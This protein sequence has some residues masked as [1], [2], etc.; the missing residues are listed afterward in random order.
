MYEGT[1]MK[2]NFYFSYLA[3]LLLLIIFLPANLQA[4]L[5]G[6]YTIPGTPFATIKAAADSLNLAGVGAGGVTFNVTAGY[7][8]SITAD[9]TLTATGSSGSAIIFQKSGGGANPLITRTDAGALATSTLG[10]AGDAIIRI[11][12]TDYITFN[13]IDVTASDQGIEYGYLTHKPDGTNGC[14]FVTITNCVV[15][16]TKGTSAYVA[17]IYIGNGT[18]STS[19]A[20]GVTVTAP[21]GMN[22]DINVTGNTIQNVHAGIIL[23]G[24]TAMP[25]SFITI[26][27]SSAGN[28]IQNYGGGSATTTYGVYFIYVKSPS[29]AYNTIDNAGGGGTPHTSILYAVFYSSGVSGDL[30]C[31]NNSFTLANAAASSA[32]YFMYSTNTC[33]SETIENN[34]FTTAGTMPAGSLYFIYLSNGTPNKTISGNTT[35]GTI[36]KAGGLTYCYYNLGSPTSGTETITNNTFSNINVASGTS[37]FYGFYTNT[38]SGQDRVMSNNT[39]SNITHSGTGTIYCIEAI[40][41]NNNQVFDNTIH[42][43]TGGG[44]IYCLYGGGVN[45]MFYNNN[46]YS[47]TSTTTSTSALYGIYSSTSTDITYYN[48]FLSDLKAPDGTCIT[49]STYGIYVTT[50]TNANLFYNTVYLDY[51]SNVATNNSAGVY[52]SSTPSSI[53]MRNNIIVNNVDNSVGN[54]VMA[55]RRSNTTITNLSANTNNNL[56]YA[57]TPSASHLIFYDGT[58]A[59][60]TLA[61]YKT[62]VSPSELASITENPPFINI[63]TPPYDL[64]MSTSIATQTESGGTPVAGITVDYDGDTRSAT[65]PDVGAD[66]FNGI[67][68]DVT[69]PSITYTPFGPTSSTSARTLTASILDGSGV[70]T[71][72]I[73]L[74]V[75]YWQ[76]NSGSWNATTSTYLSGSDYEFT[77]GSGVTLNDTVKYYICA[78]DNATPSNVGAFPSVGA[79]GFTANPPAAA[80]PPTD[81]SSYLIVGLPLSGDYTVGILDFNMITGKNISFEKVIKK[82]IKEVD[83]LVPLSDIQDQK[84]KDNEIVSTKSP[85]QTPTKQLIEVE[86]TTWIPME[87]GKPYVGD[88]Y[89]KKFDYPEINFPEGI[90]GI[91]LTITAAVADLNLRGVSSPVR[92]LLT[93]A[94]YSTGETFPIFIDI[95]N[96]SQPTATNTVTFK[97]NTGVTSTITSSTA[98]YV[99]G[100]NGCDYIIFDGSNAVGGTTRDLSI[101]ND[102]TVTANLGIV[103]FHNGLKG[104]TNITVTNCIVKGSPTPTTSYG[105]FLNAAGGAFHNTSFINNVIKNFRIGIQFSGVSGS[106]TNDGLI[107]GN[108]VG[109]VTEPLTVSGILGSQVDNLTI[110]GNEIFG[111]IEGNTTTSKYGISLIAGSTNSKIQKNNIHDFYYTGTSGYGCFGIRYN[112]DATTVT[113]ISNNLIYDIKGDGDASSLTYTPAGIY[114][115]TGGNVGLYYNSIYMSGNTLGAGTTYNGRSACV[116]IASGITL[117]DIRD[118]IFQNSM[119]SFPGS[120]RINTT[121]GVYCSSANTAFT[122]INYNDYFVNGVGP[123]VGYL[124]GDQ[125]NLA[126]WQTATGQDLNS[127]SADPEFT[128]LTDLRPASTSPVLAAGTPIAGITTDYLGVTRSATNPSMGA[129]EMGVVTPMSGVYTVGLNDFLQKTG[130]K[131]YFETRTR[132]VTKN[133]NDVD[134]VKDINAV[135][136]EKN[137]QTKNPDLTPHYVTV[138]ETY[139]ELMENGKPFDTNF[140]RDNP[141]GIYPT[142]TAAVADLNLRGMSGPVTFSL[143]DTYYP[144]ETYP[145][146]IDSVIGVSASNTITIKPATG[147]QTEIPGN[148]AQTSAT[149]QVG[150]GRY[151]IIDGSNTVGGTTKD[152]KIVGLAAGTIPSI[153]L[154]GDAN[155]NVFKNLVIESRNTSTASGTFLFGAGPYACDN[156][157]VENCTIKNIDT[158]ATRPGVGVY[159][160]SSNIGNANQFYNCSIYDFNNYGFRPYGAPTTNTLI[161]GCDIYMTMPGTSTVYGIYIGR[162]DGL[163]IENTKVRELMSTSTTAT[164]TGIY[165]IASSANGSAIVRNN[166]VSL[167]GTTNQTTGTLRGIDYYGYSTNSFEAYFNSVYIGGTNVASGL[168]YALDKRDAATTFKLY[169]NAAYNA[170]SNGAGVG[171]H[172]AVYISN[173]VSTTFEMNYNDYFADGTG[174]VFGYYGTSA[175]PDLATWIST[176]SMDSNSVSGNPG[177]VGNDDLHI[178]SNFNTLDGKGLYFASVPDDIDG[179]A[180]NITTPDIGADEYTYTFQISSPSN[181][182]AIPDTFTVDLGWQDNSNNEFGFV[183]QRK[184]GDSLSVNPFVNIDTVNVNAINYLD[185]GLNPN[186]TY[187]YRIFAYTSGGNSGYSNMAEVTTFIPVELTTFTA[188]ISG[189]EVVVTWITATELNNRGFDIERNMQGEWKKIGFKDGKGTTTEESSYSFIDKFT[190]ESFVGTISYRLKQMDFDGSYAYSPEVEVNV[191]FTPK[192]YTLYQNYPN[193]FNPVTTIKYSLPFESNVRIAVY[194]ILGEMIDVFVDETKQVGFHDYNWNA[195][196]LA[197]GIYIYTIEAKSVTGDK[198][199]S[200]VKKMILMK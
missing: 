28:I 99:F 94:D 184:D 50:G 187:T 142:I 30:A 200:A 5:S 193:P 41:A 128:G 174:G 148:V 26:G 114:I 117:L 118:N 67:P 78:Q 58:N 149:I 139:K 132:T 87:N 31:S 109:D 97:P 179:E 60:S 42:D 84:E 164:I 129:Y 80:T 196:N 159:F 77:F 98:Q 43:V 162:T 63:T 69:P 188:E 121:Y 141:D 19:S 173:I 85:V 79:A 137:D 107:S 18:V 110:T 89:V 131:I 54:R 71:V 133:I 74:P 44:S 45:A 153:H 108:I 51:T 136:D 192:E 35:V 191:D 96:E 92:F 46:I 9:L 93:D 100:L 73:G 32:S 180:R 4:Q 34:T 125:V 47:V 1:I 14:K 24:S 190:Y 177:Y 13:G 165:F 113:E 130:R 61:D 185:T 195:S 90:D 102:N 55:I 152:L 33:D 163:I 57:G 116:S 83:V 127:M 20:V 16:L 124:G 12:G 175:I 138:T 104:A 123:F 150:F 135:E 101:V 146:L 181:L 151:V 126:A 56:Y 158:I 120:T 66:E 64:H 178:Q 115:I 194:N 36:D 25:D 68:Q 81:P 53:D 119:D 70:P 17:G 170:R 88:L 182:V 49:A 147:I 6:S 103:L 27:Q 166:F 3:F 2:K 172:Y 62:R 154:Y 160:F 189:R 197:S 15:T 7:T 106:K 155:N 134:A 186:S 161:S 199:Y 22:S 29:V 86:E 112:S 65:A 52:L 37:T 48:N 38:A 75:L 171:S 167:S 168:S 8:E 156:N 11:E 157:V 21:S 140:F 10:G 39:F 176:T 169:N 91:Y 111:Q 105:L 82:V 122:N 40:A 23:R 145:I 183:I 95:V 72:G 76:I 144:N 198:S 143:V 59:D